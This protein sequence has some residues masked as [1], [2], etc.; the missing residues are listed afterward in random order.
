MSNEVLN[1]MLLDE[2]CELSL[3]EL[4]RACAMHAEWIMDL[5]AEGILEPRE[6]EA[7]RW[8]FTAPSLQRALTVLHLQRDLGVNLAGAALALE[9]LEEIETLRSRLRRLE[10]G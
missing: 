5:V 10:P 4:S 8:T 6:R 3:V 2:E 1:G 9:L 7:A